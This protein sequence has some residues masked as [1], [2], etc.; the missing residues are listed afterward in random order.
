MLPATIVP[1]EHLSMTRND[2]ARTGKLVIM[3]N[4]AVEVPELATI[5]G[6]IAGAAYIGA[7]EIILPDKLR[8]AAYTERMTVEG[9]TKLQDV[10]PEGPPFQVMAVPQGRDVEE[11]TTCARSLSKLKGINTIGISYTVTNYFKTRA[12]AIKRAKLDECGLNLHLLGCFDVK[13]AQATAKKYPQIRSIDSAIATVFAEGNVQLDSGHQ[14]S[15][16]PAAR[17]VDFEH[18]K[19]SR[20]K[21]EVEVDYWRVEILKTE[22]FKS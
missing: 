12:E 17:K 21:L 18:S 7:S 20:A 11:W 4:S 10:F 1:I 16:D 3:D 9:L 13:E 19:C 15:K 22:A 5:D 8:E 6:V 2:K 14:R